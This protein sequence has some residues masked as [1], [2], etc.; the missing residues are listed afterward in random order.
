ME[1]PTIFDPYEAAPDVV[2][3][4][5]FFP[6]PG[7]GI[8]PVNAFVLRAREPV[9]VDTGLVPISDQFVENLCSVIDPADLRWLW[10]THTD[11]DHIGSLHRVLEAAP[12][13]RVVTTFL[14]VGKMS[15]SRPL[16]MDRV[17]LLNPGQVLDAGDRKLTAF[18]PPTYD[19]PETTGF[20]D[21]KASALFS[22][23][24]FG[25]LLEEP[26]ESAAAVGKGALREG[27]VTWATVD[28]PWMHST[29]RKSFADNLNIIRS[30]S[31]DRVL[32]C[33][34]PAA[35]GMTEELLDVLAEAPS[36]KPFVGPDQK[37]LEAMSGA[38]VEKATEG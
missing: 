17:F 34:L 35:R 15:L 5:S 30:L 37:A 7:M 25:A 21:P 2:V 29:D 32:S 33:H 1:T 31:P 11:L 22:A 9:L 23:D 8:L 27:M 16:P 36:A 24:S 20:F 6:I 18:R 19:A 10:L 3:L 4:P 12:Q 26:A 28:A 38:D 13:S 14:G